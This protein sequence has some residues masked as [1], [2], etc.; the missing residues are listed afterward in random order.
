MG[1][2]Q[3]SSEIMSEEVGSLMFGRMALVAEVIP[4]ETWVNLNDGELWIFLEEK[5]PAKWPP[6]MQQLKKYLTPE[7]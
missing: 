2:E 4:N 5:D 7:E 1:T 6:T 3:K